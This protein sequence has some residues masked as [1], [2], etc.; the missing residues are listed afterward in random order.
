MQKR[1]A[2]QSKQEAQTNFTA[3]IVTQIV[4]S[5]IFYRAEEYHQDYLGKNNLG[6][7]SL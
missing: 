1:Q 6:S 7:C 3:P 4:A 5:S 2:E